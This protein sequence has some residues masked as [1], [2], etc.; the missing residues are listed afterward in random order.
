[1]LKY[2]S[3]NIHTFLFVYIEHGDDYL[4]YLHE[5]NLINRISTNVTNNTINKLIELFTNEINNSTD[6]PR[7][8]IDNTI[9]EMIEYLDCRIRR[10]N[11]F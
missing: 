4:L 9:N 6:I 11:S 1:M 3:N 8:L 2:K 7:W 10:R 5:N